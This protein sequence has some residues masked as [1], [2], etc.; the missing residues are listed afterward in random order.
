ME[1]LA[2]SLTGLALARAGLGKRVP[3]G[4]VLLVAAANAPDLD[5][6][7]SPLGT[8]YYLHYHRGLT[9]SLIGS[10]AIGLL[11]GLLAWFWRRRSHLPEARLLEC[12]AVGTIGALTH[13]LLDWTNSYGIRLLQPFSD[14]R[15]FGDLVFIVDPWLWAILG[16]GTFLSVRRRWFGGLLWLF[17]LIVILAL[18]T[19]FIEAAP[20]LR[21][22]LLALGI[23]VPATL[24]VR[25][26]FGAMGESAARIAL[27]VMAGY[28][29]FLATSRSLA[30]E[31]ASEAL[32]REN[33]VLLET[34]A[35]LPRPVDVLQWQVL[36]QDSREIL[37]AVASAH[38][39]G[40]N[41]TR[42]QPRNLESREVQ[43][44][45]ATCPGQVLAYFGRFTAFEVESGASGPT[46]IFRDAR[47]G[48]RDAS[49]FGMYRIRLSPNLDLLPQSEP[50]PPVGS[51][52]P[53]P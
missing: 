8:L 34:M 36:A 22:F 45:L 48:W 41:E 15:S 4:T 11:L 31:H 43:A 21:W 5:V 46:V 37:S 38:K 19:L 24:L 14:H 29:G 33:P 52:F 1:N 10:L 16:T 30:W 35:V 28:W 13:P 27:L 32:D 25:W 17:G 6:V 49:G 12:L 40:L 39:S 26:K 18:C 9:H 53:C 3:F 20:G 50:C 47:F 44:A 23:L 2:H 7:V 42:R 51:I